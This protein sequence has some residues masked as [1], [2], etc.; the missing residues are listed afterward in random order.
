MEAIV[1]VRQ[2]NS[3]EYNKLGPKKFTVLPRE[4]EFISAKLEG[5]NK[6]FQ[7]I[8]VHHLTHP[9]GTIEIYAVEAGPSWELKK[10]RT[11]GFGA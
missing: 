6:F 4:D 8:A 3:G 7:V 1:F 10:N 5:G 9:E 11:I 2:L